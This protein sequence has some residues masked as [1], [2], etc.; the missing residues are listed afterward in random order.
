[1]STISDSF[2]EE[3][4]IGNFSIIG[5]YN[6]ASTKATESFQFNILNIYG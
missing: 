4:Q 6:P 2:I 5:I 1:M 3:S